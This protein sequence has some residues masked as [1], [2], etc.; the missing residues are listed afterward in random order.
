MTPGRKLALAR[1]YHAPALTQ[2]GLA[3]ML[4]IDRT[5]VAK[6]ETKS[7]I[8]AGALRR[9]A[10]RLGIELAWFLDGDAS[11]PRFIRHAVNVRATNRAEEI[12]SAA[13]SLRRGDQV[14]LAVWRGVMAGDGDCEFWLSD[15][16]EFRAIP[17][18]L[19]SSDPDGH[20]LCIASGLS[21]TP[22][23]DHAERAVV[24]LDPDPPIGAIVVA[25]R[26]DGANFIKVL[27][28]HSSL[29]LEL[30]S[31]NPEFGPI[32]ELKDWA[33]KG[34]VVAILHTYTGQ[35]ANIEYDDG[36]PLRG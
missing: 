11:E 32:T 10:D 15:T 5:T 13:G 36:R 16:P 30:H 31:L 1:R 28:K 8:P 2:Q 27:R 3:D 26:P 34:F 29:R 20:V 9:V 6:W 18:F 14:M 12:G 22:R 21:M 25:R 4:G 33:L 23:I 7:D 35:G 17:S 19:A 24:R